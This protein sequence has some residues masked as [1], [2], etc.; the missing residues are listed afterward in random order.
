MKKKLLIVCGVGL[1]AACA[2]TYVFYHLI[3]GHLP[4]QSNP[5]ALTIA[6]VVAARD[7]ARGTALAAE[8][9]RLEP[10]AGPKLPEGAFHAPEPLVGKVVRKPVRENEPVVDSEVVTKSG[11]WLA[12]A[13]PAGM[14]GVTVHVTEFAGVTQLIQVGDRVDVMV[15]DGARSSG[16]RSLKLTTL[17]ENVE[18]IATGREPLENGKL[19]TIP[20]VTVAVSAQDAERLTLADHGGSIR[21]ALRNPLDQGTTAAKGTTLSDL[22]EAR[23]RGARGSVSGSAGSRNAGGGRSAPADLASAEDARLSERNLAELLSK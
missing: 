9:L 15:A 11:S 17:L 23:H 22:F 13:I 2:S 10:W 18:V 6:V 5:Q 7:L 12:A 8:D 4:S 20:T 3:S 19:N 1:L 21:L 16:N 14:R